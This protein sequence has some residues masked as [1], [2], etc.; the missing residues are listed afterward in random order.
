V[1]YLT[2]TLDLLLDG[3]PVAYGQTLVPMVTQDGSGQR[4]YYG[5]NIR[6]P[7]RGTFQVF[8]RMDHTALLGQDTPAAQFNL[9]VR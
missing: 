5:N 6:I 4:V 3:H 9:V 1:P 7:A 8:V 2:V